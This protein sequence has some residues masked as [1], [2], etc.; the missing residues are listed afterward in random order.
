[1]IQGGSLDGFTLS[2]R[3][4]TVL[5]FSGLVVATN[6]SIIVH[7]N[8]PSATCN[9]GASG[10]EVTSKTQFPASSF[11]QN[12]DFAWD[13]YSSDTGLTATDNVFTLRDPL[14]TIVDAV[15]V[16]DDPT[17][18]A[19]ADSETA[20]ATVAAVFQWTTPLGD[21]PAGGFVDDDFCL[22]A[23]QDLNG[24]GTAAGG[25]SIQRSDDLDTNHM[26]GWTM[27]A[28]SWGTNNGGQIDF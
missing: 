9:P 16:A 11:P 23:V 6:D 20:A 4:A 19:A 26:I 24:T 2:E 12:F 25:T 8:A 27:G 17:G 22:N 5:T 28:N 18:S 1:V 14:G 10:S 3:T 21:I 7:F 13:V 15:L